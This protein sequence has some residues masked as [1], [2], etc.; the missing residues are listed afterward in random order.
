MTYT[1]L[2]SS[3]LAAV[4][5]YLE[6]RER[7]QVE[8]P[9]STLDL[10]RLTHP[11]PTRYRE[12]FRLVGAPWLWFSRLVMDDDK[13]AAIVQHPQVELFAVVD[14]NGR[15]VG[16]LELDFR[17]AG[18]CELAFVGLVPDLSGLG[19]GRW[20]LDEALR[21]AWR[22]TVNRVH[23]HTC[24][25]DH[26]AA[27]AAYRRAGFTPYKRAIERFP[28]PR[29]LGILPRDCAPQVP[30]LGTETESRPAS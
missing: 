27:L 29:L 15:D 5:T 9:P 22:D 12:L 25:L 19:H 1:P 24:T 30:L 17:E 3:E 23:V 7:P 26:P 2:P 10:Q 16:M 28:D 11:E 21:R 14:G 18:E 4:V 20:L 8:V 6:M 13:L